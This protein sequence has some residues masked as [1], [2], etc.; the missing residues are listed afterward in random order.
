MKPD[1]I[2]YSICLSNIPKDKI[3]VDP[4]TGKS[5]INLTSALMRQED[6]W[7]NTYTVYVSQGKEEPKD[8]RAYLGKG[9]EFC[10][11]PKEPTPEM[12]QQMPAMADE[13]STG[14]LPF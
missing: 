7:G 6:K 2:N 1:Y 8:D 10:Y 14:D 3:K 5:W 11:T 9:K 4:K 12:V 13:S